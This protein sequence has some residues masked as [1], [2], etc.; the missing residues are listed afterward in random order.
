VVDPST[1][2]RLRFGRNDPCARFDGDRFW[3]ATVTAAGPATVALAPDGAPAEAWGPGAA[4]LLARV[5]GLVGELDDPSGFVPHHGVLATAVRRRGVPRL[6]RTGSVVDA[7]VQAV[8][9]QKVTTVQA[10]RS[11]RGLVGR[12]GSPAPGPNPSLR[13]PPTAAALGSLSYVAFHPLEVER[14]RAEVIIGATRRAERLEALAAVTPTE[15]ER[16]LR[17]LPGVGPWTSASVRLTAL[18]DAD[19]VLVGDLHL[20]GVVCSVLAGEE[21]G[22]DERMLEL[23]EPYRGHRARVVRLIMEGG[24][25]PARRAPRARIRSIARW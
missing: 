19:A 12:H 7:L 5:P 20:P 25:A 23:L 15:A 6:A 1:L 10:E 18:G 13:V 14:R 22:G 21:A 24:L 17:S 16:V 3:Y 8:L 4:E 2:A 11:W 9:G